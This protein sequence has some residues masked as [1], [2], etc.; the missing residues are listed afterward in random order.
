MHP[1]LVL[2]YGYGDPMFFEQP[3]Y[4]TVDVG[5]NIVHAVLRVGYPEAQFEFDAAVAEMHETRYRQRVAQDPSLA[6]ARSQ[7]NL[8]GEFRIVAVAYVDG[9]LQADA[10]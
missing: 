6:L 4:G 3:P 7:Q 9:Q 10:G 2:R 5:T 1:D 8:Q